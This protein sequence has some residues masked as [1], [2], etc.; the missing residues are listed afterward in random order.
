[1][2]IET[3]TA[4]GYDGLIA[5]KHGHLVA[6]RPEIIK[7]ATGNSGK[8]DGTNPDI[9]FSRAAAGENSGRPASGTS[10][11]PADGYRR[12]YHGGGPG[13]TE[14]LHTLLFSTPSRKS[15]IENCLAHRPGQPNSMNLVQ[16]FMPLVRHE[17]PCVFQRQCCA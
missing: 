16:E 4:E 9:R 5:E 1:M 2:E 13:V 3:A 15:T 6:F 17:L 11:G 7:S 8:F 14:I 10:E 12:L